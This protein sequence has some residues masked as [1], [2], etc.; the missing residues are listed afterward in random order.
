MLT[1]LEHSLNKWAIA[2]PWKNA[3]GDSCYLKYDVQNA[4]LE[5]AIPMETP[6]LANYLIGVP[7]AASFTQT[8]LC[9]L[10]SKISL[11]TTK[12]MSTSSS[13]L[14][15]WVTMFTCIG[16]SLN[17]CT[18]SQNHAECDAVGAVYEDASR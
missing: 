9:F 15:S 8:I 4:D 1:Y 12:Q 17:K 14:W 18:Q 3:T 7:V 11:T 13:L 5:R 10:I 2:E 6:D 16:R